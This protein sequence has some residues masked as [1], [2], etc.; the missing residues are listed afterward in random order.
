MFRRAVRLSAEGDDRLVGSNDDRS[1]TRFDRLEQSQLGEFKGQE[2]WVAKNKTA[3]T[4]QGQFISRSLNS[5]N[6]CG[7]PKIPPYRSP[8]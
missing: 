1:V 8:K 4:N 5:R 3:L 2:N 7:D 6:G